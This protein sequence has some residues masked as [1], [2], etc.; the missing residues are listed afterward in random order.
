MNNKKI[1]FGIV[2]FLAICFLAFTFANPLEQGDNE[3]T[4]IQGGQ[5][6]TNSGDNSN[7]VEVTG[8]VFSNIIKTKI[9]EGESVDLNATVSPSTATDSK[10]TYATSDSKVL[11]VDQNG[12]VTGVGKGTATITVTSSNGVKNTITITVGEDSDTNGVN[13]DTVYPIR[14]NNRPS[15]PNTPAQPSVPTEISVTN[16]SIVSSSNRLIVGESAVV[17]VSVSPSNA[18]NKGV[19][20][21]SDNNGIATVDAQGNI[22]AVGDGIVHITATASNGVSNFVTIEVLGN[23]RNKVSVSMLSGAGNVEAQT[24]TSSTMYLKG[25]I[26]SDTIQI[27][28]NIYAPESYES[29]MLNKFNYSIPLSPFAVVNESG[30]ITDSTGTYFILDIE[31]PKS[32]LESS[33]PDSARQFQISV[34]WLGLGSG[35]SYLFDFNGIDVK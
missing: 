31:I 27:R 10:L 24:F 3:G 11:T 33:L 6:T 30:L 20:Y 19:T 34:D 4:L 7:K 35:I 13:V 32:M 12:V 17:S 8:I 21:A 5:N 2:L 1:I 23:R 14:D 28:T 15:V 26:I 9:A 18:T 22:K 29:K 16:V 25:E